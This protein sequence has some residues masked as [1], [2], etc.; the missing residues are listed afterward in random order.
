MHVFTRNM[1]AKIGEEGFTTLN[2][3]QNSERLS[4]TDLKAA[5]EASPNSVLLWHGVI[6][7]LCRE[8]LAAQPGLWVLAISTEGVPNVRLTYPA[9]PTRLEGLKWGL[10]STRSLTQHPQWQRD[11]L[12]RFVAATIDLSAGPP[13]WDILEP[14]SIPEYVL[15]CYLAALAGQQVNKSWMAGFGDD[16][17]YW[18]RKALVQLSWNAHARD[19]TQLHAFL[20]STGILRSGGESPAVN[21]V[22]R[23]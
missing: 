7:S 23:S 1:I 6:E 17:A 18:E 16:V 21:G 5:I 9:I 13:P 15:A 12:T 14:P 10:K 19:V 11:R 8:F 3:Q 22:R 20:L 2:L 4:P